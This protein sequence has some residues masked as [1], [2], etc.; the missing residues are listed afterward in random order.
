MGENSPGINWK[1]YFGLFL[2]HST[3]IFNQ[4][5]Y[6]MIM[7]PHHVQEPDALIT[8]FGFGSELWLQV[9]G[10]LVHEGAAEVVIRDATTCTYERDATAC[11]YE[12]DATACT[13]ERDITTCAY[14][15]DVTI[16]QLGSLR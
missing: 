6:C 10:F 7:W 2:N 4:V 3:T 8:R 14:E 1:Y 16:S 13:Y 15:R 5:G 11:M 9:R 12:R